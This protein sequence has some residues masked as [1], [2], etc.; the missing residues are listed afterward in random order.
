MTARLRR[1]LIS[2]ISGLWLLLHSGC[3]GTS[4]G[5]DNPGL[6]ELTISF[7]DAAGSPM[8]V[9]GD[10]DVFYRDQNPAVAPEPAATVRIRN[11]S[12]T[13]LT[14]EDFRRLGAATKRAATAAGTGSADSVVAFNLVFRGEVRTGTLAFGLAYDP[15]VDAFTREGGAL[16]RIDL[17][18]RTL[19]RYEAQVLRDAV[20]GDLGRVFIPG[21]P[22]QSTLAEGGFVFEALPEGVFPLRLLDGAGHIYAVV[23]SLDTKAARVF[24][25]S[26]DP[27]GTVD[28]AGPDTVP[29]HFTVH[30]GAD[31]EA[32]VSVPALLEAK[33]SGI[34]L[35]S[36]D[37]RI[38][39]L[40]RHLRSDS[41]DSAFIAAPTQLRTQVKFR[42]P[43]AYSFELSVTY[44]SRSARD[45]V[46]FL[47]REAPAPK[48]PIMVQ[49]R[50][51]DT[52]YAGMS[53][54]IVWEMPVEGS[55]VIELSRGAGWIVIMEKVPSA[56]G[57]SFTYWTPPDSLAPTREAF[58]RVRT[59]GSDTWE[60]VMV[61]PFTIL[62]AHPAAPKE[63]PK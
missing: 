3:E 15:E 25:A 56:A 53:T 19:V 28:T 31:Q 10:L 44:L 60:A 48:D 11:S 23:E 4:S 61:K 54:K 50:P 26:R 35:D 21:T 7:R 32:F 40:W 45:T 16:R 8:R 52:L 1:L 14:G 22:Y 6:A 43:G 58:L 49:P 39:T 13:S 42:K 5:V 18:P 47:V 12:L 38:A 29:P 51:G 30:A 46:T 62:S 24:T 20:H 59:L 55:A 27:I 57:M 36:A 37:G 9:T 34:I 17:Q 63:I 41:P 2:L 33:V